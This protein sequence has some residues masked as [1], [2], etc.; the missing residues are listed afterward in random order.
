MAK[1]INLKPMI[2]VP[3]VDVEPIDGGAE[4]PSTCGCSAANGRGAGGCCCGA[5]S[6][7]GSGDDEL[8]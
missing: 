4:C 2:L 7:C 3:F 5:T 1:T 6:G 8:L